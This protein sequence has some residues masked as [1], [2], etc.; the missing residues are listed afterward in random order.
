MVSVS[1]H[2]L[3][4]RCRK[5]TGEPRQPW[6]TRRPLSIIVTWPEQ[7]VAW[8]RPSRVSYGLAACCA[9][10]ILVTSCQVREAGSVAGTSEPA[11]LEQTSSVH[12]SP[13]DEP[14]T[15]RREVGLDVLLIT[16]DTLRA[17]ALGVYGNRHAAT[18][19]MDR[20]AAAG[21]RFENARAHNVVTL[22]SHATILSGLSPLKH[23]VRDNSGFRFPSEAET[24]ATLLEAEGYRTGAFVSAFPL[25]SRF[26]LARGFDVYED[27]FVDTGI[28]PAFFEQERPGSETVALAK[29]WLEAADERPSFAWVHI[30]E[31]HFPYAPPAPFAKR[32]MND[33]YLGDVAA[34]DAA[35]SPLLQPLLE[36]A[37]RGNT[38]VILTSDHG[39]SL[40]EHGEATHG[41]FGYEVALKVPLVLYQPR[42]LGP[43][44]VSGPVRLVDILP[45]V[46]DV[47][48]IPVPGD[49]DGG[50]LLPIAAG[51]SVEDIGE[52]YF[53]ALSG[54]LNRG[55]APLHGVIRRGWKYIDLP[56]P[57]LYE[58]TED[59]NEE[60][61]L[62]L[63]EPGQAKELGDLLRNLRASDA[64]V[65]PRAESAETRERLRSL[66]YLGGGSSPVKESYSE[67]DDPKRLIALDSMLREITGLYERGDL[68]RA[69]L[70]CRELVRRRPGMRVAL[71][72]LGQIERDL[73]NLDA[74]VDA[75][76][77]A[78]TLN[79]EDTTTLAVLASY[80][81]QA[82]RAGDAAALT[83]PHFRQT[84]PDVDVLFSRGL[85]LARIG[86]V[87][88]ALAALEK[89]RDVDPGNPM[90][91]VYFGT[92]YL[93][94]G[95]RS[96]ARSSYE[97][98]LALNPNT[99]RA[100]TS[101]AILA[102]EEG[103]VEAS[104]S[105][106]RKAVALDPREHAKLFAVAGRMWSAGQKAQA[107]P[108]L[109][110]FV[111][112]A[113]PETFGKEIG[114]VLDLLA[115]GD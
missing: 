100:H 74:A 104:L 107:R 61:N 41:I 7:S 93:M 103:Q 24:L 13:G 81:V 78:L 15:V 110:L 94:D 112:S 96:Q 10:A 99:V 1:W 106:W 108:L 8:R 95:R 102:S 44:L 31:P 26:G 88:E 83:E 92:V 3:S 6:L 29:R 49:L 68:E 40:G 89:A 5:P 66:G 109:E 39:E 20:L 2:D 97:E 54:Q 77:A 55:W 12:V 27:S 70:R 33:P 37:D 21:V 60:I 38:L 75:M 69:R 114:R 58:L 80:L 52:T 35:L 50:S 34:A 48:S 91:P 57:E 90:V 42:L 32:F 14:R 115:A 45:T 62:A 59:P 82:G 28:K 56:I 113:P 53:E 85:A 17:D 98:A 25:D 23:G 11:A 51:V 64:G 19:W 87:E 22:P 43:K 18:P 9:V 73:G 47:L 63:R 79:P 65:T 30:Y 86:K 101:L 4:V 71:M 16:V 76:Q 111:E 36:A 84:R 72:Q 105:N 67:D 46:L